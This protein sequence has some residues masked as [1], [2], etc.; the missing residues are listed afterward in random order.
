MPDMIRRTGEVYVCVC[1]MSDIEKQKH[2]GKEL[3]AEECR[4]QY[5]GRRSILQ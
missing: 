2:K 3:W 5:I 4:V 1:C